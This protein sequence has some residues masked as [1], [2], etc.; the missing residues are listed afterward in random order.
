[1]TDRIATHLE[2]TYLALLLMPHNALRARLQP[3]LAACRDALALSQEC[4]PEDIQTSFDG[5]AERLVPIL[6]DAPTELTSLKAQVKAAE[7][8]IEELEKALRD[9]GGAWRS[10]ILSQCTP[11]GSD[12]D[13]SYWDS[14]LKAFDALCAALPPIPGEVRPPPLKNCGEWNPLKR[15]LAVSST[16]R[17]AACGHLRAD[18]SYNGACYG[19]CGEFV[20]S[21]T[22]TEGKTSGQKR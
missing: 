8:R 5:H 13:G 16:D 4:D 12:D 15:A 2:Q 3:E 20:S 17:C 22:S 18:H 14:K 7:E 6:W 9:N 21:V 1:M 11:F 10:A 19:L